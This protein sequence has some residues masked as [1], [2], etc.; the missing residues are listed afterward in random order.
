MADDN[1]CDT[2][3]LTD[4]L[5]NRLRVEDRSSNFRDPLVAW[6]CIRVDRLQQGYRCI[7]L[8]DANTRKP[9]PGQLFVKIEKT[10]R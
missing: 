5:I 1:G 2:M 6:A 9:C 7:D 4:F 3:R 10:V 8:L